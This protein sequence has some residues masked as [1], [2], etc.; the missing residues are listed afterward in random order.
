VQ[1]SPRRLDW[2]DDAPDALP[3]AAAL[4]AEGRNAG[5]VTTHVFDPRSGTYRGIGL[6]R[7]A[8]ADAGTGLTCEAEGTE[9]RV[10]VGE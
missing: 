8:F 5:F 6:I 3:P 4:T 10:L 2:P 7:N 1:R 9:Y